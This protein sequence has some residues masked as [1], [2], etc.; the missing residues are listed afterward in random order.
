VGR[1]R[2]GVAQTLQNW[3]ELYS[4]TLPDPHPGPPHK[5]EGEEEC[6]AHG[7]ID[8]GGGEGAGGGMRELLRFLATMVVFSVLG[9]VIGYMV[10][11]GE[12]ISHAIESNEVPFIL[13]AGLPFA[14]MIGFICSIVPL[15]IGRIPFWL[16]LVAGVGVGFLS[17]LVFLGFGISL[18]EYTEALPK[19]LSAYVVGSGVCGL[20]GTAFWWKSA[21]KSSP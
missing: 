17:S 14:A 1:V 4:E 2:V 10:F 19:Y 6:S 11:H 7:E 12:G 15:L 3:D 8:P 20:L 13:L 18:S 16:P 9:P 5:G 21:P